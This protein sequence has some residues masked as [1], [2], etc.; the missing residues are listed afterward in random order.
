MLRVVHTFGRNAGAVELHDKRAVRFGRAPDNDVVFD[1]NYDRDASTHHAEARLEASGWVL[2]DLDSR[3]GTYVGGQRIKQHAIASGDEVTFGAQGPRVRLELVERRAPG[4]PQAHAALP[5]THAAPAYVP[6]P[7]AHA[8]A[9][10]AHVQPA[11]AH[12]HAP[13]AHAQAVPPPPGPAAA[14]AAPAG[15]PAPAAGYPAPAAGYPA[16]FHHAPAALAPPAGARRVGERTIAMMIS[17]AVSAAT[18]RSKPRGTVELHAM[19]H[20]EVHA[21]TAGQRRTTYILALLLVVALASLAGL[22]VYNRSSHD[23]IG[24]L[25]AELAR[26]PPEDPRRKEIERR[27]GTL[28]PSNANFGRNLHDRVR[29][30]IFMLAAGREGFCT[31]FAVRPSVLATNAHCIAAAKRRGGTIVALENEGRGQISF[32]VTSMRTH[33]QYRDSADQLTPD[34]GV[35]SISGRAAAV[36]ELASREELAAAGA[37]DDVYLI[38]FPERLTDAANP[39]ATFLAANIGRITGGN[40]RPAPAADAWL[41]QHDARSTSG[42]NG[43]PVFNGQGKVIGIN[44][45]SYLEG[46]DET[47]SG[48]KT[49]VVKASPYKFG[50][51]IDLLDAILR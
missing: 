36:L 7:P 33:P 38:G 42:M 44:A 39:V 34:V 50:M 51:R 21:A 14:Y 22:I 26:L 24:R 30:G 11:H 9:P 46:N 13:P 25:R 48:Q 28:H 10:P 5:Q 1:A 47:I 37:G 20:K 15:Y 12:A 4:P 35:V 29:K 8:H 31:A 27:L 19:L 18:G 2:H 17:S 43:S 45:G 41:I 3:N 16:A 49:E 32:A 6:A 23:E 40:G